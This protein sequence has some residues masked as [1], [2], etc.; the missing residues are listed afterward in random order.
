MKK[1]LEITKKDFES[2]VFDFQLNMLE[3]DWDGTVHMTLYG[4]KKE[5]V[6]DE[7][8]YSYH[9]VVETCGDRGKEK[10]KIPGGMVAI[11]MITL[12]FIGNFYDY[13]FCEYDEDLPDDC[14]DCERYSSCEK[15]YQKRVVEF[16]GDHID[17][18]TKE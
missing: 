1:I 5:V 10:P 9:G 4:T 16:I 11:E 13:D 12:E 17:I 14:T 18:R 3:E 15:E 8:V 7:E 6:G 2:L